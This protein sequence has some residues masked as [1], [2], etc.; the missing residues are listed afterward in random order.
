MASCSFS[1][2]NEYLSDYLR[3]AE[4]GGSEAEIRIP[5]RALAWLPVSRRRVSMRFGFRADSTERG[6]SHDEIALYWSSGSSYLPDFSGTVRVRI[7]GVATRI[8]LD[9]EYVPPGGVFGRVFDALFGRWI[10]RASMYDLVERLTADLENREL[11]WRRMHV[12]S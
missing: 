9:G 4:H 1:V 5:L 11:A 12:P 8:I 10:A 3:E 6:R 2:A 7:V